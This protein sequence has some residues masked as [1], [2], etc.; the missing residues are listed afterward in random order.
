[1]SQE[2]LGEELKYSAPMVGNVEGGTRTPSKAFAEGC[3]RVFETGDL[4]TALW[5]HVIREAS[6]PSWFVP[7]VELEAM[8]TRIQSFEV[9]A[10]PGLLQT[11]DYARALVDM[12][13]LGTD[14]DD[15]VTARMDRQTVFSRL[16]PPSMWVVLDEGVLRRVVGGP[17]VMAAQLAHILDMVARTRNLVIQ[18]LPFAAGAHACMNG[19]LSILSMDDGSEVAY[20]EGMSTGQLITQK[21]DV[22]QCRQRYDLAR[23]VAMDP[24]ASVEFIRTIWEGLK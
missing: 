13:E 24:K 20:V 17:A 16:E 15:L 4:F 14:A 9:Q 1:M 6:Y 10:V 22:D 2:D 12:F 8:A 18:V 5:P 3:D 7:Y 19:P 21:N 11:P 23:A